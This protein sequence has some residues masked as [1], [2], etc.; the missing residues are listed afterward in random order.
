ML[1]ITKL[2]KKFGGLE[3]LN[4]IDLNVEQGQVV[5]ILGSS[6]SGKTTLLRCLNFLESPEEGL[7]RIGDAR[8][9]ARR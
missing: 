1:K 9:D 8:I 6:G 5:A 3:V 7:I 2:C 4:G